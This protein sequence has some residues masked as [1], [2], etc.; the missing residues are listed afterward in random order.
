MY[1]QFNLK[2]DLK[3]IATAFRFDY[4]ADSVL[5]NDEKWETERLRHHL[6]SARADLEGSTDFGSGFGGLDIE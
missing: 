6:D 1:D 5:I 2:C 3:E 4:A